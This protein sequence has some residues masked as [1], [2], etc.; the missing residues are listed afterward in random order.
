MPGNQG[1][2]SSVPVADTAR[3]DPSARR[4][5]LLGILA[6]LGA[7]CIWGVSVIF[8]KALAHVPAS[9]IIAH[10]VIWSV[11]FTG[12]Y[13][14]WR[15]RCDEVASAVKNRRALATLFVTSLLISF[16]WGIFVWAIAQ[17]RIVEAALG[18]FMLPLVS[19][20]IGYVLLREKL[21]SAQMIAVVLALIAVTAQTIAIGTL[22]WVAVSLALLFAFYGFIRKKISIGSSPGLFV[23]VLLLCLPALGYLVYLDSQGAAHFIHDGGWTSFLLVMTGPMTAVPLILFAEAVRRLRLVSVGL[24]FYL[25]P[26]IQFLIGAG[27]YGE[28]VSDFRLGTFALIWIALCIFTWDAIR[29][30]RL[31]NTARASSAKHL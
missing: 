9:E 10:R 25:T 2:P 30:E 22:P 4:A 13:L 11:V 21:N 26:T 6:A 3:P 19:V 14:A 5:G 29:A 20:A 23:E 12:M 18:Y 27:L 15:G 31:R 8:F 1:Q 24:I 28:P 7:Y 16:N 17:A